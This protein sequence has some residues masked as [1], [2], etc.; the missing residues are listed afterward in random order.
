MAKKKAQ[1]SEMG[2]L[3]EVQLNV[4]ISKRAKD[5]LEKIKKNHRYLPAAVARGLIESACAFYDQYEYFAFPVSIEPLDWKTKWKAVAEDRAPY[6]IAKSAG[7]VSGVPTLDEVVA[8]AVEQALKKYS[9]ADAD[10]KGHATP[11]PVTE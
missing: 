6:V 8:R 9:K 4:A 5:T 3:L 2:E 7:D 11:K 1:Q 10:G